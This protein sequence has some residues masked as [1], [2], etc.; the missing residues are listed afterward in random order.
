MVGETTM[1]KSR[2]VRTAAALLVL[3]T[4]GVAVAIV[5]DAREEDTAPMIVDERRGVL[6]GVRFGDSEQRVRQR[7]GAES[8]D[9]S[10]VFP[11]GVDYTGPP[12]IP[13]PAADQRARARPANLHYDDVAF[14]VSPSVGV[15]VMATVADGA[16]TLAGRSRCR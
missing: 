16:R 15:F 8:D 7:L 1:L 3:V 9:R 6:A 11:A 13:S 5:L 12:S 4:I 2:T 14:L 10:G